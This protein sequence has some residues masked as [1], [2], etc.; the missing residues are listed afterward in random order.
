MRESDLY[1]PIKRHF[2]NLGY[3]VK[4]EVGAA[5]VMAVRGNEPAYNYRVEVGFF[6]DTVPS[7]N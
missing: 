4:G 2:Q 6:L 5:D 7:S 3:V 1:E